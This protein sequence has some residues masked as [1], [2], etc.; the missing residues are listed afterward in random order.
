MSSLTD[1]AV[2]IA[3]VVTV[4]GGIRHSIPLKRALKLVQQ[5]LEENGGDIAAALAALE[6]ALQQLART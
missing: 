2:E 3:M 6:K 5:A 1:P 4:G